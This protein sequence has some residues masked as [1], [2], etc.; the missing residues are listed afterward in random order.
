MAKPKKQGT[1]T[2]TTADE[3]P[4]PGGYAVP[5]LE[6]PAS[7]SA[8]PRRTN[9]AQPCVSTLEDSRSIPITC[10]GVLRR[11]RQA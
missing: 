11:T 8:W 3:T 1:K 9:G 7:T 2:E 10:T 5:L 4:P 6:K